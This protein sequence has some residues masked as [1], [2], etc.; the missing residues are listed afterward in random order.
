MVSIDT[1][2]TVRRGRRGIAAAAAPLLL[3]ALMLA[4]PPFASGA[5]WKFLVAG[6]SIGLWAGVNTN[7]L[8]EFGREIA[9]E[10][11][12]FVVFSGDYAWNGVLTN[13]VLWTNTLAPVYEAGIPVY[14]ALGNHDLDDVPAFAEVFGA[15]APDNG[16]E[17]EKDLTFAVWWSN[18]LVLV[19]NVYNPTNGLRVNQEWV[20]AVLATNA[21]PHVFAVSHVPAFHQ[22]HLDNMDNFPEHRDRFWNSLSN[23]HARVYF[24]GHDHF[25]DRARLDDRDGNPDND[26]HQVVVGTAGAPFYG[27]G[28]Y[29][30]AN[31]IWTPVRMFHEA[32]YGYVRVEI[33]EDRGRTTWIHR[34]LAGT[35]EPGGDTF[36][37]SLL[38]RPVLNMRQEGER[39]VL[40]WA[41]EA[42]LEAAPSPATG[43]TNIPHA[44]SPFVVTNLS[45]Q[46]LFFRLRK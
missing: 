44:K 14:A 26:I 21:A 28:P 43:Y 7:V 8:A 4:R 40:S 22:A 39:V 42:V 2:Q 9:N 15:Q 45:Q 27:E 16:P 3:L 29:D 6:D 30:G 31:S 24:C 35:Y 12:A 1:G 36:A 37:W 25:Y 11:P 13:F 34:T 19:L 20:D 41:G 33:D 23:A 18:A 46:G 5:P 32:Q 10:K 17:G 38:P